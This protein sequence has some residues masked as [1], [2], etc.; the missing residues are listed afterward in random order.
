MVGFEKEETGLLSLG[1]HCGGAGNKPHQSQD[2]QGL[3]VTKALP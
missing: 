3:K 2:F 1:A